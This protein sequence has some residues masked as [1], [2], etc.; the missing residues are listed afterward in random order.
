MQDIQWLARTAE[1]LPDKF[2][3]QGQSSSR[4]PCISL[5][6]WIPCAHPARIGRG[7][8]TLVDES[9]REGLE[10]NA[11]SFSAIDGNGESSPPHLPH[12][13]GLDDAL[14]QIAKE[15][16]PHLKLTADLYKLL[17]YRP[18]DYF[19]CHHDSKKGSNHILTLLVVCE[20]LE[21]EGCLS[22]LFP[23]YY[24]PATGGG[25]LIF[26]DHR[27]GAKWDR[28]IRTQPGSIRKSTK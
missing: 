7:P 19:K 5:R 16:T 23:P 20:L 14:Q 18:G 9:V 6:D 12:W 11:E 28:L 4:P 27:S 13:D 24:C 2:F 8:D 15:L 1:R 17:I 3:Y 25:Q 26:T 21:P 22:W 10:V